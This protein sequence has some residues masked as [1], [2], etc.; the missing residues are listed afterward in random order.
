MIVNKIAQYKAI[1]TKSTGETLRHQISLVQKSIGSRNMLYPWLNK[2]ENDALLNYEAMFIHHFSMHT[3]IPKSL[4]IGHP[5]QA[6][7]ISECQSEHR[8]LLC[9]SIPSSH[10]NQVA[11]CLSNFDELPLEENSIDMLVLAH[12][13]EQQ[14]NSAKFL[15]ECAKIIA[16][17][18]YMI[19]FSLKAHSPLHLKHKNNSEVRHWLSAKKTCQWLNKLSYEILSVE[20]FLSPCAMQIH[21]NKALKIADRVISNI[22]PMLCNAHVIVAKKKTVG[23]TPIISKI[24][25]RKR[26]T[27]TI[28]GIANSSI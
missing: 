11:L 8:Y 27:R 17:E 16:P 25:E 1:H 5:S 21:H 23:L 19:I 7:L 3:K 10:I 2:K 18:G 24:T 6:E 4:L 20:N 15:S 12:C 26:I 13:L 22:M 14:D 28:R 9:N